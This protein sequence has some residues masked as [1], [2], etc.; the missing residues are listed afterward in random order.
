MALRGTLLRR[1][2]R[3]GAEPS[4]GGGT[5]HDGVVSATVDTTASA[6]A[7]Q[8]FAGVI[9]ATVDATV[10]TA[11]VA[12]F[13]AATSVTSEATVAVESSI[14]G[15]V[16]V[17]ADATTSITPA[18]TLRGTVS[19]SAD[20]TA[21]LSGSLI[22]HGTIS[23]TVD[24][25]TSVT[26]SYWHY[27]DTSVTVDSTTVIDGTHYHGSPM[28]L[29]VDSTVSSLPSAVTRR[30]LIL[31]EADA[32][33]A[34]SAVTTI[35][36]RINAV[37]HVIADITQPED[38]M[39]IPVVEIVSWRWRNDDGSETAATW[40][41]ALDTS[42]THT[43]STVIR[44]R[45][46]IKKHAGTG[47]LKTTTI[48]DLVYTAQNEQS[49][50]VGQAHLSSCNRYTSTYFTD[51]A[52]TTQQITSG[53]F[54]AGYMISSSTERYITWQST[55]EEY[56][57]VEFCFTSDVAGK[58][59]TINTFQLYGD[60]KGD[61]LGTTNNPRH[62]VPAPT[63][64]IPNYLYSADNLG[65]DWN[66]IEM[67]ILADDGPESTSSILRS[68]DG[69][70][71]YDTDW[72]VILDTTNYRVR[73]RLRND[74]YF[75]TDQADTTGLS[76]FMDTAGDFS[77]STST[78]ITNGEATTDRMSG[79]T[80]T[81]NG[82]S[83]VAGKVVE[84]S[85][86]TGTITGPFN[87]GDETEVEF[88]IKV[89][90]HTF[91]DYGDEI[92]IN[93]KHTGG[94][95]I[96]QGSV[97]GP[98]AFGYHALY[99]GQE[100]TR[101]RLRYD[102]G[103]EVTAEYISQPAEHVAGSPASLQAGEDFRFRT[104]VEAGIL[105]RPGTYTAT[106][107]VWYSDD[108]DVV[109]IDSITTETFVDKIMMSDDATVMCYNNGS[110]QLKT[111]DWVSGA[112]S[113]QDTITLGSYSPGG[114]SNN[115]A[116]W[117]LSGDGNK[118]FTQCYISADGEMNINEH[119]RAGGGGW[120]YNRQFVVNTSSIQ[121]RI[122]CD[123]DG[124][125]IVYYSTAIFEIKVF[126]KS[127]ST[128]TERTATF[129]HYGS[130]NKYPIRL[131][132]NAAGDELVAYNHI[133][134]PERGMWIRMSWNSGTSNWDADDGMTGALTYRGW[135][136]LDAV[137]VS[138]DLNVIAW[139]SEDQDSWEI[140][141]WDSTAQAYRY[142]A[143][144]RDGLTWNGTGYD[145]MALDGDGSHFVGWNNVI[146]EIN[147]YTVPD[148]WTE[149]G[150]AGTT[151]L[152]IVYN[153]S[154]NITNGAATTEQMGHY[155]K[156][157]EYWQLESGDQ[158]FTAGKCYEDNAQSISLNGTKR[159]ELEACL[160]TVSS[161]VS[162]GDVYHLQQVFTNS[163]GGGVKNFM[164]GRRAVN[165]IE[166]Q[167]TG[168]MILECTDFRWRNDDGSETTATWY[169]KDSQSIR[170][171]RNARKRIRF[172]IRD[173]GSRTGSGTVQFGL[174]WSTDMVN[175]TT[176]NVSSSYVRF[177]DSSYITN[178][179]ATT[180]QLSTGTFKAG[181]VVDS[182]T[183]TGNITGFGTNNVTEI[184]FTIDGYSLVIQKHLYLRVVENTL[185]GVRMAALPQL[186]ID[187]NY[188]TVAPSRRY[189][190]HL[191]SEM[192]VD[193]GTEATATYI[194]K[195][196]YGSQLTTAGHM[197]W[198]LLRGHA[199]RFR[200]AAKEYVGYGRSSGAITT[201][202]NHA[203]STSISFPTYTTTSNYRICEYYPDGSA[204]I[205][206]TVDSTQQLTT[207]SFA[208]GDCIEY[209]N[210]AIISG[211]SA[212]DVTENEHGFVVDYQGPSNNSQGG[213]HV[214][215][216]TNTKAPMWGNWTVDY[217][218]HSDY[219][220]KQYAYRF[221]NEDGTEATAT[222][223]A[224]QDTNVNLYNTEKFRLR[225]G[226]Q[227]YRNFNP[228]VGNFVL[229]YSSD[230]GA[231]TDVPSAGTTGHPVTFNSSSSLTDMGKTTSQL[232]GG[233]GTFNT[234][235]RTHTSLIDNFFYEGI[236]DFYIGEY[237]EFEYALKLISGEADPATVLRFRLVVLNTETPA[238]DHNGYPTILV[239]RGSLPDVY[240]NQYRGVIDNNYEASADWKTTANAGW[241]QLIG[242]VFR[243][244]WA[245]SN[246]QE[247]LNPT[248]DVTYKL[249]Y[250]KNL[251]GTFSAGTKFTG[252]ATGDTYGDGVAISGNG[253]VCAIGA[254]NINTIYIKELINGTWV[255]RATVTSSG[256]SGGDDFGASIALDYT[257]SVMF[258]GCPY[259]TDT[260]SGQGIVRIFDKGT[261]Y[262][263]WTE[264]SYFLYSDYVHSYTPA[265]NDHFGM[266][267][268]CDGLGT[269]LAVGAP[270]RDY[271]GSNLDSGLIYLFEYVG[272]S[273]YDAGAIGVT[274]GGWESGYSVA[275]STDGNAISMGAPGYNTNRGLLFFAD[276]TAP[277]TW[278]AR[279]N[280]LGGSN[281]TER[282]GE[283]VAV[284]KDGRIIIA[285]APK[286]HGT[287]PD[288]G[289]VYIIDWDGL[290]TASSYTNRQAI[291]CPDV[292]LNAY[293]G[294]D[295]AIAATTEQFLGGEEGD[296]SAT[297][298]VYTLD[299]NLTWID[300]PSQATTTEP[301]R[302]G[303]SAYI[304]DKEATTQRLS[305]GP[306]DA[307][308]V[309][310]SA[311]P[312]GTITDAAAMEMEY[313]IEPYDAQCDDKDVIRFRVLDIDGG[314]SPKDQKLL[315][316]NMYDTLPQYGEVSATAEASVLISTTH[317][318]QVNATS[319]ASVVVEVQTTGEVSVTSEATVNISAV[320]T[321]AAKADHK[322]RS[323]ADVL[324]RLAVRG[325]NIEAT[326]GTRLFVTGRLELGGRVSPSANSYIIA[327]PY[328]FVNGQINISSD[329]TSTLSGT[330]E[331][332]GKI[333]S[334]C[335]A[336]TS[337]V[338]NIYNEASIWLIQTV[339][340]N[341]T[342]DLTLGA[343]CGI[344]G[345][346][347]TNLVAHN[348]KYVNISLDVDT[349]TS[350]SATIFREA[351]VTT[352]SFA[353]ASVAGNVTRRSPVTASSN[354][355]VSIEG[356]VIERCTRADSNIT[357]L[358]DITDITDEQDI[359]NIVCG[360]V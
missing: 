151:A 141:K 299:V 46:G 45:I 102:N 50:S 121:G 16:I 249:Q 308:Q 234:T 90:T 29:T 51:G 359:T 134:L 212:G 13:A 158:T 290:D 31:T 74:R 337:I 69:D 262:A 119:T 100:I 143:G 43:A 264:R 250:N 150:A 95:T 209:V 92:N 260:V 317:L 9:S 303:N 1:R 161:N 244:R 177:F 103:T 354:S 49:S 291:T 145:S 283:A 220:Y 12:I 266:G 347:S 186:W 112:W 105:A 48:N 149:V 68:H 229:Q 235:G 207:G 184:E 153:N 197:T 273:W 336:T 288:E 127:G 182:G 300:V 232:T 26:G 142:L 8:I 239:E 196:K 3:K 17:S 219:V 137:A 131:F 58:G 306:F 117:A 312:S 218:Y 269:T 315:T 2:L 204:Y 11:A 4:A 265:T 309:A 339:Q 245:M 111:Y 159:T 37:A 30:G 85:L 91:N 175:F 228:I 358:S 36:N 160:T 187:S 181:Q 56:S 139:W 258:V 335:D 243:S 205:V 7:S 192:R 294:S 81:G 6:S 93:L 324:G 165:A 357:Q 99:G 65:L 5:I 285:G 179:E 278:V 162:V 10:A 193:D 210:S 98:N 76:L 237:A 325:G 301:V 79:K 133:I 297:G 227:A 225:I 275:L 261:S 318:G 32:S 156:E 87:F 263:Q 221:R 195:T 327:H 224:A 114:C 40:K 321:Y 320:A 136:D 202:Y 330:M 214:R 169:T 109:E 108:I 122:A 70:G 118:L 203:T 18:L 272:G 101:G 157:N 292:A 271:D 173:T 326:F 164:A 23:A 341:I 344:I 41:A 113:L 44:L 270:H 167:D 355:Y 231:W 360:E 277:A 140:T 242:Q 215:I 247:G 176:V 34:L 329:S 257:G 67:A 211:Y 351:A 274:S 52:A 286:Y 280:G 77:A 14:R 208:V 254:T 281:A 178:Q 289:R 83:F 73:F 60:S 206:N 132:L 346:S 284:D 124:D 188:Y 238:L 246:I 314:A 353:T 248:L 307:G 328:N 38:V 331:Y 343:K 126:D 213:M 345:A 75:I 35:A 233:T 22:S 94:A 201:I 198:P 63:T 42:I 123:Y 190:E 302:Y 223:I 350:L 168:T 322:G 334:T 96:V 316:V 171:D 200:W 226:I 152:P 279:T 180:Q 104:C 55:G 57:E 82:G 166:I 222:W 174:Q 311:S 217:N 267:V 28:P 191:M 78:Y 25:A 296:N 230:Y 97:D 199:F 59:N 19:N 130:Y 47:Y 84:G 86:S 170:I 155:L 62:V 340:N 107:T 148:N 24:A 106:P 252:A 256:S 352:E 71:N 125:V 356:T 304:T 54:V 64:D 154:S 66:V 349:S 80:Q 115:G 144:G 310:E 268:S 21:T 88:V 128:W 15:E 282:L 295:V 298:A 313:V 240:F 27:G 138:G 276:K 20:S 120:T 183:W 53:S 305:T 342:G 338:G 255:D 323:Y 287:Q 116:S 172:V 61:T 39:P 333:S 185:G 189:W 146:D 194:D 319:E 72:P 259:A 253:E 135:Q 216:T 251:A 241:D 129:D 89:N 348:Y 332:S 293:W 110:G 147:T 33:T 236:I 163:G